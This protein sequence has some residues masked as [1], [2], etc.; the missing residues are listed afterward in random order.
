MNDIYLLIN[1]TIF[2]TQMPRNRKLFIHKQQVTVLELNF[3]NG[4]TKC[5]TLITEK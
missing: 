3:S 2:C 5:W 1:T 4:N